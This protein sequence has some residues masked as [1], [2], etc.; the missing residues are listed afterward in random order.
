MLRIF[1]PVLVAYLLLVATT[2]NAEAQDLRLEISVPKKRIKTKEPVGLTVRM[3][4][5]SSKSYYVAGD[6]SL[7]TFGLGHRY[8]WYTLQYL[9]AGSREFVNGPQTWIP[10]S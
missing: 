6:M 4:N 2:Y 3:V 7:G 9:R 5:T 8:G 1:T 10:S